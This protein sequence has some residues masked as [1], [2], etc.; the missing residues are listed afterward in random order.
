MRRLRLPTLAVL[1]AC[2]G[3]TVL[4][5]CAGSDAAVGQVPES[6]RL[7][8]ADALA[9][10]T[11][12]TDEGS[13]QWQQAEELLERVPGARDGFTSAIS[14]AVAEEGLTW[15]GDV[16]PALG[17]E[18]VV[19]VTAERHPIGLTQPDDDEKLDALLAKGSDPVVHRS[20]GD[21]VAFAQTD[22]QLDAYAAA[23]KRGTLE[24]VDAFVEGMEALPDDTLGRVWVDVARATRELG[25]LVEE[26][27]SEFDL[28]LD[29]LSAALAAEDDGLLFTLGAR[30]PGGADTHY[31]LE[32][33]DR[34]PADA[35]AALSFGGTQGILDS[36]QGSVD[37]NGLSKRLEGL[38]GVSLDGIVDALSGEGVLYVREGETIPEVTLALAPPDPE[39]TWDTLNRLARA[40]SEQTDTP[41]TTVTENGVEVRRIAADEGTLSFARLDEDTLIVTTG[42]DAMRVFSGD[43][44]KLVD[45]GTFR[46]AADAVELGDRTRGFAYV[47]LDGLIPFVEGVAPEDVAPDA[48]ETLESLDS[49]ILQAD[50]EGETTTLSGFLR[51]TG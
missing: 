49:F 33:F 12:T 3:A 43:G 48:R 35:V 28:G 8:P 32:L 34:V 41:I 46:E 2:A 27:S 17:P 47:D 50:G 9:Y 7:A 38:T 42:R 45:A 26:A 29:W 6:A 19:V 21:W 4:S 39:E 40:L 22:A 5:G 37:L 23:L 25:E 16:A 11:M 24:S 10:V 20:V 13:G 15:E 18:V 44:D 31:E 30:T 51:L 14:Q 36:I 1:A